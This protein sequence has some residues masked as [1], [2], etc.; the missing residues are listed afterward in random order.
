MG[1]DFT[2]YL[3]QQGTKQCATTHDTPQHN[4]VAK[5]LNRRLAE[6]IR[7]VLHH[8]GLPKSLWGEAVYHATW[9]KNR[10]STWAIGNITPHERLYREKPNLG[11]IPEWGQRIWVHMNTGSKLD[12]RAIKGRWVGY[13]KDST[14]AHQIY[15]PD[16]NSVGVERD[17]RF[18]PTNVTVHAGPVPTSAP[19]PHAPPPPP[20]LPPAMPPA[21]TTTR[22][23]P[24]N[25]PLPDS[26]GEEEQ[27][28]GEGED[29]WEDEE[30]PNPAPLGQFQA[31]AVSTTTKTQA[32]TS[33]P[34][35]AQPTH[36]S[37]RKKQ[38]G[39]VDRRIAA[40]EGTADGKVAGWKVKKKTGSAAALMDEL[41]YLGTD[42]VFI[43][44]LMPIIAGAIS[45]SREDPRTVNEAQS[46]SDWPLWQQAMD[47]KM[48]MLKDAGTW[49]T[50]PRPT[51]RNIVGSKWV[52]RIKCKADGNIN[53]YKA[54][55]VA[56]GFTQI[57]GTGY[58]ETYSPVAKLS[59]LCTILALAAHEDWD[60]NC[61]DFDGAYLNGE[62]GKDEDIYMKNPPGYDKGDSTI[63]H[64]KKSLY[65]LKQ[66]RRKWYDTLKRTLANLGFHVSDADPS[67]FHACDGDHPT[68]I[69]IHMD[70][71][72]IISSSAELV[73]D[74]KRK[75]NT[76]HSITDLGPIH[77]LLGI[78]V[79]RN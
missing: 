37:T 71:C 48:K 69:A 43:T 41:A 49:E 79:T 4:G 46:R 1:D 58:F 18:T 24:F 59:S 57:Y 40:G 78:K 67:V 30:R 47:R 56:Q 60:I 11:R 26:E 55:L 28:E 54:H 52:F 64:L 3:N 14:H 70:N 38:P 19:P 20:S 9:L 5:S 75:I 21:P 50:V 51:V 42:C 13:D 63:K 15:F 76:C 77:W 10:T 65:G 73:Q 72:T 35:Y 61:F 36:T 22:A 32:R 7:A 45:D 16:K 29:G 2:K 6:R 62:L 44:E 12:A 25:M 39:N 53:K 34:S 68:I 66:A 27:E 17:V 74:Y 33:V 8:S 31:P 23:T